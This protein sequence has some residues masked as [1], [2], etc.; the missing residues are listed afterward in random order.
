[1]FWSRKEGTRRES[2][3]RPL[4]DQ[5]PSYKWT[6]EH[7][8]ACGG[9]VFGCPCC[10]SSNQFNEEKSKFKSTPANKLIKQSPP[11]N[12]TSSPPAKSTIS[13]PTN[14]YVNNESCLDLGVLNNGFSVNEND[15][16]EETEN[17]EN[18]FRLLAMVH[19]QRY[20]HLKNRAVISNSEA[21]DCEAI[22]Q[23]VMHN[24][25]QA[26]QNVMH[27][28]ETGKNV[29]HKMENKQ[30][31][32]VRDNTGFVQPGLMGKVK[33]VHNRLENDNL[34]VS[35]SSGAQIMPRFPTPPRRLRS[36]AFVVLIA[37]IFFIVGISLPFILE[38]LKAK[39]KDG[40]TTFY[41]LQN[42]YHNIY[43]NEQIRSNPVSKVEPKFSF[44]LPQQKQNTKIESVSSVL[45]NVF[46]SVKTTRKFHY[47]RLV[48]LLET[49][50]SLVKDQ[51]WFFTDSG[52][53]KPTRKEDIVDDLKDSFGKDDDE[54][55]E[56]VEDEDI[57]R[58]TGGHLIHTNC[59]SSH[60]RLALCCKMAKEFDHFI[61]S[62]KQWWC[63]FDDDNYVNVVALGKMLLR[64][65]SSFPWYLGKTSTASPLQIIDIQGRENSSFWFATGGAGFCVSRTLA[66]KMAP[67]AA[68]GR[69]VEAGNRFWFPD[70]VTFGYIVEH[71]L[72]INLTVIPEFHSHLEPMADMKEDDLHNQIS[73]SYTAVEG[74]KDNVLDI[75]GPFSPSIDPTRFY[76]LHC[77]LYSAAFCPG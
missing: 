64:F 59:S 27:K 33:L 55:E 19:K 24:V 77:R 16:E 47:P 67:Y 10:K 58:R 2:N 30:V 7:S 62:H 4:P 1:M 26:G 5:R 56:N 76:S 41:P 21:G 48:I 15:P 25:E 38:H 60:D 9:Q 37:V 46:I 13:S 73:F 36:W 52:K 71:Q 69:F 6:E 63:H 50:A 70:D 74:N 22:V 42:M 39:E 45:M 3:S 20:D 18:E 14:S 68:D 57:Q 28:V 40:A 32:F 29:M 23:N 11:E 54:D 8:R 66:L 49:W 53:S 43:S 35:P 12:L 17:E 51:T 61:R 34:N 31:S 72:G 75:Q 44:Y 65:D